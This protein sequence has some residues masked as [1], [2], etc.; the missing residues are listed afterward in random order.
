MAGNEK[1]TKIPEYVVLSIQD[2][3]DPKLGFIPIQPNS[4]FVETIYSSPGTITDSGV[5]LRRNEYRDEPYPGNTVEIYNPGNKRIDLVTQKERHVIFPFHLELQDRDGWLVI[6]PSITIR[7]DYHQHF[8][9]SSLSKARC[10]LEV[11]E[12]D[13]SFRYGQL[14]VRA[15]LSFVSIEEA[16]K[17]IIKEREYR[18]K[19][20]NF[21]M[22]K[23]WARFLSS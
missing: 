23:G 20:H 15:R 11:I 22:S 7:C 5:Y 14:L 17:I 10:N 16:Q 9:I 21:F 19:M 12:D 8:T 4:L 2:K 6:P 3:K 1:V 18:E 13:H